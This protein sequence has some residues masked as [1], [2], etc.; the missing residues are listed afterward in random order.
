MI[1][2]KKGLGLDL[3]S[4]LDKSMVKTPKLDE[5]ETEVTKYKKQKIF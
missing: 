3:P 1:G 4:D 2:Q 5:L